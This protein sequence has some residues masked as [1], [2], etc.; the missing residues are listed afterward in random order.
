MTEPKWEKPERLVPHPKLLE[1]MKKTQQLISLE[2]KMMDEVKK[3][4]EE[5]HKEEN[6]SSS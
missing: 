4:L 5:K 2:N 6:G 3:V 1:L